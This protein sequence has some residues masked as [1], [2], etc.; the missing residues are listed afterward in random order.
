[1]RLIPN[2]DDQSKLTAEKNMYRNA[3]AEWWSSY[4]NKVPILKKFAIK[5]LSLTCS[6]TGC[7]RNWSIFSLIDESN[8]W[9][10]GRMYEDEPPRNDQSNVD[11]S[12]YNLR[13][14]DVYA[15]SSSRGRGRVGS[16]SRS[17]LVDEDDEV[18]I[19]ENSDTEE[20]VEEEESDHNDEGYTFDDDDDDG[21]FGD[22]D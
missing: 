7:E 11:D 5:V 3:E 17:D 2:E 6:A 4:E 21:E 15:S 9:L 13:S 20:D 1:M 14:N 8:E 22:L 18:V 19:L 12:N 16:S 10:I